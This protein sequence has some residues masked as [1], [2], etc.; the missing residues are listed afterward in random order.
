MGREESKQGRAVPTEVELTGRERPKGREKERRIQETQGEKLPRETWREESKVSTEE[1]IQ[2]TR[3]GRVK[4]EKEERIQT[5][6]PR[7]QLSG[8]PP[9][10]KHSPT[11]VLHAHTVYPFFVVIPIH[12]VDIPTHPNHSTAFIRVPHKRKL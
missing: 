7:I 12:E 8:T 2:A 10:T 1:R 6:E 3:E 5:V 11:S 9:S 4:D